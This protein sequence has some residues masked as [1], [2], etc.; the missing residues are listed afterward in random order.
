[1]NYKI[2]LLYLAIILLITISI[3]FFIET[4]SNKIKYKSVT[5]LDKETDINNQF[6]YERTIYELVKRDNLRLNNENNTLII[7]WRMFIP[8]FTGSNYW[9]N[10]YGND[11]HILSIGNSPTILYNPK[12]NILKVRCE[13]VNS[14]FYNHFPILEF[15]NLEIQRWNTITIKIN[16][17]QIILYYNGNMVLNKKYNNL[18]KIDDHKSRLVKIG[19]QNNNIYGKID[20]MIFKLTDLP[21]NKLTKL[22]T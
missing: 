19:K 15:K 8:S 6:K 14:P 10:Y 22:N 17:Y 20:N 11:K 9:S 12:D 4:T 5:V 7:S 16:S 2:L 1:M 18:L 21:H 3:Y 13:Y